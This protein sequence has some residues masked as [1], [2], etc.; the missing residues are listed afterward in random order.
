VSEP[1]DTVWLIE[2]VWSGFV[3]YVH[4]DFDARSWV[5][6]SQ[7][8]QRAPYEQVIT[9]GPRGASVQTRRRQPT[10]PLITKS[11]DE[12]MRFSSKADAEAWLSA[13][14]RWMGG[15]QYEA[16]EHMWPTLP[17]TPAEGGR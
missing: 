13:Q 10:I 3:H 12:A 14:P 7:S 1:D 8:I 2:E 16:R 6:E 11:A 9:T 5:R 17:A 15:G 4:R